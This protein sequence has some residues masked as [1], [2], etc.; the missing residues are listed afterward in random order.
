MADIGLYLESLIPKTNLYTLDNARLASVLQDLDCI[1]RECADRKIALQFNDLEWSRSATHSAGL[2]FLDDKR[3]QDFCWQD[4]TM[5]I[6]TYSDARAIG[7]QFLN[8][9]AALIENRL[10]KLTTHR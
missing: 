5:L 3:H 6:D 10:P 4:T 9:P 7:L 2:S 8:D 1:R